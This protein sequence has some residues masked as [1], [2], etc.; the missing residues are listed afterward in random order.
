[1]RRLLITL[2]SAGWLIPFWISAHSMFAFLNAELWP[3][4]R[5]EHPLNSFPFIQ[6]S[7]QAFT[8]AL[9]WLAAVIAFW[10]WRLSGEDKS[11]SIGA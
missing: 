6:F 7:E 8:I 10:A 4:L 2:F 11:K 3:R 1:M 5:G 9:V